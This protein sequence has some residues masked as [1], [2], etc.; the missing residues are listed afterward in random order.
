[1]A[2]NFDD[3]CLP[4]AANLTVQTIGEV[5]TTPYKLPSPAFVTN[6]VSPEVL[7]VER[8]ER[9]GRVAN[10][11]VGSMS[12]HAQ[13]EG[14]KEVMRVP[15]CL[16]RLLS[17]PVMRGGVDEKHAQQHDMSGNTAGLSVVDLESNLW[18]DLGNLDIVEAAE[19][20]GCPALCIVDHL[21]D[22]MGCGMSD[23]EDKHSVCDLSV[24]PHRLVKRKP[25]DLRPDHS[26]NI[27]AHWHN[28]DHCV[29]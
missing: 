4:P 15:E 10:K 21:L 19:V 26:K 20:N 6:A 9:G 17:D 14:N 1:M 13:Q 5:Q 25:S 7:I 22:V 11:A 8:R 29:D 2:H 12:I 16:K 23:G 28:D 27:S 3:L 24:K 18:S